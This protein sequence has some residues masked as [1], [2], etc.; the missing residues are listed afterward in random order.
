[1]LCRRDPVRRSMT[2]EFSSWRKSYASAILVDRAEAFDGSLHQGWVSRHRGLVISLHAP[3]VLR[4]CRSVL[5]VSANR[6]IGPHVEPSL[7][8]LDY[9]S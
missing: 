7:V 1:M 8:E 6:R 3:L 2:M 9:L 5:V 4:I